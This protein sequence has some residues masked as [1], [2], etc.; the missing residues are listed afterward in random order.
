MVVSAHTP[1]FV[2]RD[3]D[4]IR[5]KKE[6]FD[7]GKGGSVMLLRASI[8]L[9]A[10]YLLSASGHPAWMLFSAGIW[11][12]ICLCV[13]PAKRRGKSYL[14]LFSILS[15][16]YFTGYEYFH[17]R[18]EL[19]PLAVEE[20][21]VMTRGYLEMPLVRDGDVARLFYTVKEI[22][23][24]DGSWQRLSVNERVAIRVKLDAEEE[25]ERVEKWRHNSE[26]TASLKLSTPPAARNPYAFDYKRYLQWQGVYAVGKTSFSDVR[27]LSENTSVWGQFQQWQ[28]DAAA[29]VESLFTNE[30]TAGYMKSLLLGVRE[31]VSPE[32]S[33]MYAELGLTHVLAISGLHVTLVSSMFMWLL[34]RMGVKRNLALLVT[35][36]FL[37]GY[38]LLVGASASAVRSGLMGG[39]GLACQAWNRRLDGREVW[40]GALILMLLVDPYQLWNVG[41]QLSFAVTLGLIIFVPYSLHV[42]TRLPAWLRVLLAVTTTAQV[43]SFPFLIYHFHQFSFLSWGVNLIVTPILSSIVL[44]LGYMALLFSLAH[45]ALASLPVWLSTNLLEWVHTPLFALLDWKIPYT[46]WPHPTWSW[47][48][49]YTVFL[50]SL[51]ILWNR[52]YHRKRDIHFALMLFVVLLVAARQPFSGED[53]VKITFLDVGQGDSIIVEVGQQKV[54][55]LDAGG[56]PAWTDREPWREKKDPFEVGEDVVLPFLR[57]R[58]ITH[59]DRVV[60]THGDADHIGGMPSLLKRLT[61]G[62]VLV[63]P[64]KEDGKERELV[65]QFE[66]MG[67]PVWTGRPG[68]E[69]T[70]MPGVEWK[71]LHPGQSSELL[72]NDASV[73]LQ[74]TAFGKTVLFTGDIETAGE[75]QLLANGLP[76]IDV[77]KVAH[78][79][80]KTSS[81][82]DF[83]AAIQPK[84]AVISV[85]QDNRYGHPAAEVLERLEKSVE[86]LY[87]TDHHGAV[88]LVISPAGLTWKTVLPIH[89]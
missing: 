87:R 46:H 73:V 55:L 43:V 29:R 83:L 56:N 13:D 45:P 34:E 72:G 69:W 61:F 85:G 18:S 77:L 82:A 89:N 8:A 22:Q 31:D 80:S 53:E 20:A 41:F 65:R 58:G 50:I 38:V 7:M 6:V 60:L 4:I 68:Q 17:Q 28:A 36:L 71:W 23:K 25:A 37:V 63:N 27:L 16:L 15:G 79:G 70:D 44:P 12:L 10:G 40:A 66:S 78:H 35:I 2:L 86:A 54:Y 74:L 52:G 5:A 33:D 42:R 64:P 84:Y 81:T 24:G 21:T 57:A 48:F 75:E 1:I 67:V 76:V 51:P 32:W 62:G 3:Q 26:I 19:L 11:L 14:V 49:V 88:T 30:K 9:V 47:L 59:V 39:V